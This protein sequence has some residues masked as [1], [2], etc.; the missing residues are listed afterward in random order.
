M[1]RKTKGEKTKT[2]GAARKNDANVNVGTVTSDGNLS[3]KNNAL[4][5]SFSNISPVTSLSNGKMERMS[6]TCLVICS[7]TV[8]T[9]TIASLSAAKGQEGERGGKTRKY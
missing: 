4:Q 7:W 6:V 8:P 3:L 1:I 2:N 5:C 9:K